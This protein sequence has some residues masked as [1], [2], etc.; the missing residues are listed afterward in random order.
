MSKQYTDLIVSQIDVPPLAGVLALAHPLAGTLQHI[1]VTLGGNTLHHDCA[2]I[3]AASESRV[4]LR[5]HEWHKCGECKRAAI[6]T[7]LLPSGAINKS[8]SANRV[9]ESRLRI[10]DEVTISENPESG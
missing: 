4:P 2:Q 1:A 9:L 7:K 10:G 5:K 8:L 6:Q 3:R